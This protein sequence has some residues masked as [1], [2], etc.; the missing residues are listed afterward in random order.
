MKLG[1]RLREV[2]TEQGLTLRQLRDGL[3]ET[4][5]EKVS[6]SY[7]SELEREQATPS[8][9]TV[10][11]IARVFGMS[12]RDLLAPVDVYDER[13]S[14]AQFT[15]SLQKYAK[16]R[17]LSREWVETLAGIQHRGKRPETDLEWEAVYSMLKA[18]LE[19]K[20]DHDG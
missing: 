12:T 7:L 3:E 2:R 15:A 6:I 11:N 4:T 18:F 14:D 10:T 13:E 8:I 16:S 5:G 9:A 20:A 1:Q 17:G 19:P